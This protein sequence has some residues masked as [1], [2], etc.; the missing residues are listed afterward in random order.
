MKAIVLSAGQGKRLLPLTK[1][2]PKCLL[3]VR[4]DET[5][6]GCQLGALARAGIDRAVVAI[7]FGARRV[8]SWLATHPVPGLACETLI[9]PFYRS[10][11]NLITC[12]LARGAMSEDF[13]LL[14]GDTI[15][16]DSVLARLLDAPPA[17]ITIAIDHKTGYDDDDMKVAL[18]PRGRLLAIDKCLPPAMVSGESIGLLSFHGSGPKQ[19]VAALE[20]AVRRPEAMRQWYLSA[21]HRIA[22]SA[23]VETVSVRGLWWREVDYPGD[24]DEAR[25]AFTGRSAIAR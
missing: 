9:N 25:R 6:L 5:I 8:E 10:S 17:P 11:D 16:E 1:E 15:F 4:D 18:D 19:F 20:A 2:S 13:L 24:L 14:N 12:W 21:V 3:P 22:Q 23:P 7:G